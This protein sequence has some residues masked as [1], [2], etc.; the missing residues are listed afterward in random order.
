MIVRLRDLAYA[1][2]SLLTVST[3]AFAQDATPPEDRPRDAGD[4]IVTARRMEE[5]LQDVPISMTV[6]NQEQL[7]SRNV[8]TANDLATYTPSLSVNTR[9]GTDFASFSIRG[10]VQDL[11][12]TASVGVYFADVVAPR[13]GGS[14]QGGDG[15]GPGSF[16]D[17]QNVQ[18]LK[19][20][21]GTLFGRNTTGGAVLLVPKKPSDQ[22]EGYIEG[23]LGNYDMHRVQAVLNVPLS[24]TFKV[25]AGVD[26]QQRD[27]YLRNVSGIGPS[28]FANTD[29]FAG[30]LSMVG[31][32]T[33]DL[34]NYTIFSYFKSKPRG[35]VPKVTDCFTNQVGTFGQPG[36]AGPPISSGRSGGVFL[37]PMVCPQ[38]ARD[39]GWNVVESILPNPTQTTEQWQVINTTTWTASDALTIKNIVSYAQLTARQHIDLFGVRYVIP[40]TVS[41]YSRSN[42]AITSGINLASIGLGGAVGQ[43]FNFAPAESIPNR[44]SNDQ[45]TFSEELQ[46]QGRSGNG[47]LVW[48]AGAYF[49]RSAPLGL[50]GNQNPSSLSCT[51]SGAFQCTDYLGQIQNVLTGGVE[52]AIGTMS[53]Q[54]AKTTFRNVGLYAQASYDITDQLKGTLGFRYTWDKTT[55][56]AEKGTF[57]FF[58]PNVPTGFCTNPLIRAASNPLPDV[59]STYLCGEYQQQESQAPTWVIGLDYKPVEDLLLYAKYSRGYRQGATQPFGPDGLPTYEPEKVDTYELG[60]KASFRGTVSGYLNV[61]AFYNDFSNQQVIAAYTQPLIAGLA[62]NGGIVNVG[63]SRIYGLEVE[64]LLIPFRGLRIQGSYAYLNSTIQALGPLPVVPNFAPGTYLSNVGDQLPYTPQHKLSV[65]L[66]YTLPLDEAIGEITLGTTYSYT[67]EML[68]SLPT[69]VPAGILMSN[70]GRSDVSYIQPQH[71]WNLNASWKN[72]A[73]SNIDLSFFM[74]NLANKH[75]FLAK[76]LQPTSGF[77]SQLVSEPRMWGFRARYNF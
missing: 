43:S 72:V 11:R 44:N 64:A 24:D 22:L 51:N 9:F 3:G 76:N 53:F 5:R 49:E 6:F 1:G 41:F 48:Q 61:A 14:T 33:P 2:V 29:Y 56:Y 47:R 10:F 12:T 21:Q 45:S 40:S 26:W 75:Y 69:S 4:I 77:I 38:L 68:Y 74:T 20:P 15:A 28:D 63:K 71:L 37:G 52:T 66:S 39:A 27:G 42:G 18:V 60:T 7:T 73:Q 46:F 36:F 67:G 31:N 55:S 25:R 16:F 70:A 32:L 65:D 23:S 13:G 30:R 35:S 54:A 57:R 8:V 62:P 58:A 17:L 19:G 34:E 50:S 59:S